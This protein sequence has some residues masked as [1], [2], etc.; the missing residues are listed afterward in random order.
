MASCF[1]IIHLDLVTH[2]PSMAANLQLNLKR[3]KKFHSVNGHTI[4]SLVE[5][6][7]FAYFLRSVGHSGAEFGSGSK[8]KF[9]SLLQ[10][11]TISGYC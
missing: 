10:F 2:L 4:F 6:D 11:D 5:G 8:S 9:M 3:M 7:L 1:E